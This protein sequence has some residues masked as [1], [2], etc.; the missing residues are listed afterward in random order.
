MAL[1]PKTFLEKGVQVFLFLDF[2]GVINH[3]PQAFDEDDEVNPD[4]YTDVAE[5]E[6][7]VHYD[8]LDLDNVRTFPLHWSPNLIEELNTILADER[9]QLLWLTSW[10]ENILPVQEDL[11]KLTPKNKA[12]VLT[13]QKRASDYNNN[14][15]KAEA[16]TDFGL[17]TPKGAASYIWIDDDVLE[18]HEHRLAWQPSRFDL[19]TRNDYRSAH[20]NYSHSLPLCPDMVLGLQPSHLVA[21]K[22]F[23]E[24]VLTEEKKK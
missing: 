1:E 21:I 22:E 17:K 24:K 8:H 14:F 10:E 23:L 11:L 9:V 13:L 5:G 15:A 3:F 19:D 4:R 18:Q 6:G 7:V 12:R 20:N 16:F 2:D